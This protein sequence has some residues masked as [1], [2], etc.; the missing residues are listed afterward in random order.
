MYSVRPESDT[1]MNV[2]MHGASIKVERNHNNIIIVIQILQLG[3]ETHV[4]SGQNSE[5][6]YI[7]FCNDRC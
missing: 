7:E 2:S 4:S 5:S 6:A 3:T 1:D